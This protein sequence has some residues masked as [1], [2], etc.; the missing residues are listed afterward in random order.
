MH[1]STDKSRISG[2]TFKSVSNVRFAISHSERTDLCEA[3]Y[4][5]KPEDRLENKIVFGGGRED[6]IAALFI[7]RDTGLSRQA[8]R[9]GASPFWE[10]VA[11]LPAVEDFDSVSSYHDAV[12]KRLM[13]FKEEFEKETGCTV[14][15][16]SVHLDEGYKDPATGL[17]S[18]N[19]HAHILVDRTITAD[20]D[21]K[22]KKEAKV[23]RETDPNRRVLWKPNSVTLAK[24]QTL[25]ANAL[26][27]ERG[28]TVQER[29]GKPS[30]KHVPH[31][32]YR[33]QRSREAELEA[34]LAVAVEARAYAEEQSNMHARQ[35]LALKAKLAFSEDRAVSAIERAKI[36]EATVAASAYRVM[37][38]FL[39]GTGKA[40]QSDYQKLKRMHEELNPELYNMVDFVTKDDSKIDTEAVLWALRGDSLGL[41][42]EHR[43]QGQ[44]VIEGGPSP[45]FNSS[46]E[47]HIK[48]LKMWKRDNEDFYLLPAR[49]EYGKRLAFV[50][51]EHKIEVKMADDYE[52][53]REAIKLSCAKWPNGFEIS[54]SNDF[55]RMAEHCCEELGI[56][57][58]GVKGRYQEHGHD[59]DDGPSP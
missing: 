45:R 14:L 10:G 24:M 52:V 7:E 59:R 32:L 5:L 22:P 3:S 18:R 58:Y 19:P 51:L 37:R 9:S 30:R 27:M 31:G 35:S 50:D 12:S 34:S 15:L 38:A 16:M 56:T 2:L 11:V 17:V 54:G 47:R 28:T 53:V 4:L 21:R 13:R 26:E 46:V 20:R 42:Q 55:V 43:E 36:L 1:I 39:K 25:C 48:P 44:G 23:K 49:N 57:D 41:L 40:K 8:K 6:E 29:G 33:E